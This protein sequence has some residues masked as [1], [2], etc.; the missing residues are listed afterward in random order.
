MSDPVPIPTGLYVNY[1]IELLGF[2]A[3]LSGRQAR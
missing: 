1:T 3:I 2:P